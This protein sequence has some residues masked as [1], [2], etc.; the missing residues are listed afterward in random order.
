[1]SYSPDQPPTDS[2]LRRHWEQMRTSVS[3]GGPARAVEQPAQA[4]PGV[5]NR[6]APTTAPAAEPPTK[7]LRGWLGRLFGG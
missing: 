1:M 5:G 4:R 3:P 2:V 6:P 7:G